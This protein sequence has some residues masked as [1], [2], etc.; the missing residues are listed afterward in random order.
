MVALLLDHYQFMTT[1][2]G[3]THKLNNQIGCS[4]A[5]NVPLARPNQ[6]AWLT[7]V[8]ECFYQ[9]QVTI[10]AGTVLTRAP[11]SNTSCI[12]S[13]MENHKQ[14]TQPRSR[15]M[16]QC[17]YHVKHATRQQPF[18][19]LDP[20][21]ISGNIHCRVQSKLRSHPVRHARTSQVAQGQCVQPLARYDLLFVLPDLE[22]MT[23][24][25]T[26][27]NAHVCQWRDYKFICIDRDLHVG[28]KVRVAINRVQPI[29]CDPS[30]GDRLTTWQHQTIAVNHYIELDGH[31]WSPR[32]L[33]R[34]SLLT[35]C[36]LHEAQTS[37]TP[38][39][40][41]N[42][43]IHGIH[44]YITLTDIQQG[45]PL[46]YQKNADFTGLVILNGS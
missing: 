9:C 7:Q 1:A 17:L 15:T 4:W 6:P 45:A 30:I 28:D 3:P 38:A 34:G 25:E 24:A 44:F 35:G 14:L 29:D 2:L 18:R 26:K 12:Q 36:R 20:Q 46:N 31:T 23:T 27:A 37:S 32:D 11:P 21:I 13:M 22:Y 33:T 42:I 39:N 5:S 10:P 41:T 19:L 16:Q 8:A 43:D 40:V